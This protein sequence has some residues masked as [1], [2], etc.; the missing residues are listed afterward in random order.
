[1][2]RSLFLL[3]FFNTFKMQHQDPKGPAKA[4]YQSIDP[5][6]N[7]RPK[8]IPLGAEKTPLYP[9]SGN[10]QMLRNVMSTLGTPTSM[11][12][13][14]ETETTF[15]CSA[16][17]R[18]RDGDVFFGHWL[19]E[20]LDGAAH[21][22]LPENFQTL[23]AQGDVA[24]Q[25]VSQNSEDNAHSRLQQAK[26]LAEDTALVSEHLGR[27]IVIVD[28]GPIQ[29]AP[30]PASYMNAI[31]DVQNYIK[32]IKNTKENLKIFEIL[33][34]KKFDNLEYINNIKIPVPQPRPK[35]THLF[36][37]APNNIIDDPFPM[38]KPSGKMGT[39]IDSALNAVTKLMI[40]G[41]IHPPRKKTSI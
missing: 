17:A 7:E 38:K 33:N 37:P 34:H 16:F 26:R 2:T 40:E 41:F 4:M 11:M 23:R 24:F 9:L 27:D 31:K 21:S 8:P 25:V 32:P 30:M 35:T 1:M 12:R 29:F 10:F 19:G 5:S 22:N 18:T 14:L 15:G 6:K 39:D 20:H 28:M 3:R 36:D 13:E